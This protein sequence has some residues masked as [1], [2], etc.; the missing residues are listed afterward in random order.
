MLISP[1]N[2]KNLLRFAEIIIVLSILISGYALFAYERR[3]NNPD[4]N[5]SWVAFYFMDANLPEKGVIVEN[6]LG[7]GTDFKFCLVPDSNNLMEPNDLSCSVDSVIESSEKNVPAGG[8][9]EWR[10]EKPENKGK[11]WVV[12]EYKDGDTLKN[13]DLS[14]KVR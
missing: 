5:K 1:R 9:V 14:F 2:N 6:H 13:K 12:L 8:T 7:Y 10:Y 4:Y 11:Y 3:N